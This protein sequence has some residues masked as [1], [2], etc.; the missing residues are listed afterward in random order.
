MHQTENVSADLIAIPEA[1]M[2]SMNDKDR[3]WSR[4]FKVVIVLLM[5][6]LLVAGI[7]ISVIYLTRIS[8]STCTSTGTGFLP[9]DTTRS[10][11]LNNISDETTRITST[12]FTTENP[13]QITNPCQNGGSCH[14]RGMNETVCSCPDYYYGLR[15]EQTN[16]TTDKLIISRV[17]S[18]NIWP[19][20]LAV[21]DVTG[22][23]I[24]CATTIVQWMKPLHRSTTINMY[25]FFNDG[26]NKNDTSKVINAT[27]GIYAVNATNI[28]EV[29]HMMNYAASKG[30][31]GDDPE[32]DIEALLY[33]INRCPLCKNII[34]IADNA[35]TP[36]DLVLLPSLKNKRI[37]VIP[38][39]V[40]SNINPALIDIAR[41][42]NGSLH[43]LEQD[44]YDFPMNTSG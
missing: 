33:G 21:I 4:M 22:S 41:R 6:S 18:R 23:M 36:R 35:A 34:H 26:D 42:T 5:L 15:C 1:S 39:Q 9:N 43:T 11:L 38:C 37:K 32:N 7:T 10:P 19:N 29:L 13:C 44:I 31:G 27:G 16:V 3:C 17:L 25:V 14:P 12:L 30:N 8:N 24:G 40:S 20:A 28:S 2:D